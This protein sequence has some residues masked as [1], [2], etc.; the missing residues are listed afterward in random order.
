MQGSLALKVH[1]HGTGI[2]RGAYLASKMEA[3]GRK[4]TCVPTRFFSALAVSMAAKG[5][6]R[7]YSCVCT[8]PFLLPDTG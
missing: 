6:P 5:T 4:A 1:L 8:L 2:A 7:E 3:S